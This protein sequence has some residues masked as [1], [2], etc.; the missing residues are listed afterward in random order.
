MAMIG[1]KSEQRENTTG[2]DHSSSPPLDADPPIDGLDFQK[3]GFG[4]E[5]PKPRRDLDAQA[6]APLRVRC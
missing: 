6:S 5:H 2:T 4:R 1:S 3:L